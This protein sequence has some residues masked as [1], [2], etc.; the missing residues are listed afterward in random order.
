MD[1]FH[2]PTPQ[3]SIFQQ[4]EANQTNFCIFNE[5]FKFFLLPVSYSAVLILGLPLNLTAIWIFFSKMRPWSPTTVY[6]F[7]LALSDTLYLLSL[8]TLI[9]YYA[10]RNNW[11]FGEPLCKFVR[12]LFYTNLYCSILFLTC[13][14]VHRYMGVCHP[15]FTLQRMKARYAYIMCA[16]VWLS[17]SACLVPNII[18]VTVSPRGNDTLCHDTT[19]PE[20]F[21]N[22]VE[23]STAVM[24]LLF[25][26]P[27]L[28]IAICYGLMARELMKPSGCRRTLP[29]YKKRSIKTIVVVLTVF[30]ICFLPFHITRTM[31]YYFRLLD[32]ECQLLNVINLLYKITRP[33]ASANSCFDPIL[34]FLAS[35]NY[36]KRLTATLTKL[37]CACLRCLQVRR[38]GPLLHRKRTSLAV[39]SAESNKANG[40]L[41]NLLAVKEEEKQ[42][43]DTE[44]GKRKQRM[45]DHSAKETTKKPR[46]DKKQKDNMGKAIESKTYAMLTTA[47]DV[48]K[49]E[50]S[51][52]METI[53]VTHGQKID[54]KNHGNEHE[55]KLERKKRTGKARG[56]RSLRRMISIEEPS[57]K[58]LDENS[59]EVDIVSSWN[60]LGSIHQ[61]AQCVWSNAE[62]YTAAER[63][64]QSLPNM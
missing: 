30:V 6:M 51:A 5:E 40:S 56:H 7:N 59:C 54:S 23:Y 25:G 27:C 58:S 36:Q 20:E 24:S 38:S 52:C 47:G 19:R 60:L 62:E 41:G 55:Q 33:L 17:V 45:S 57:H 9:Y 31:Y 13:I 61:E 4:N 49:K 22:Y 39:I 26:V 29:S 12:F 35:E 43:T 28:V 8:P 15:L 63:T 46:T 10:D 32:A 64:L 3:P 48:H 50:E 1:H 21:E 44:E 16:G 53:N 2:T 18:F 14:S 37:S 34:Y 11:P 42:V